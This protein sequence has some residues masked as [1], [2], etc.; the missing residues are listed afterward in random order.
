[1]AD[2]YVSREQASFQKLGPIRFAQVEEDV[3]R[4]RLMT[5]RRHIQPLQ[6]IGFVA[7]AQFVEPLGSV[8]ELRSKFRC[9]FGA[10][11]VATAANRRTDG[12]KDVHGLCRILHLHFADGF[13]DDAL[14][15]AAPTGVNC[16]NRTILWVHE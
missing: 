10:H 3:L 16:R 9:H 2:G 15:G 8:W 11:F 6:G 5:R 14:Q 12:S 4:R 7:G 1:M 13:G